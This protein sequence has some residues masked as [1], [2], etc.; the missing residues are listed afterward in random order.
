M[1][2]Q[3][4]FL[5]IGLLA[6]TVVML[7]ACGGGGSGIGAGSTVSGVAATGM[8]IA[9]GQVSL[10]CAVGSAG[11]TTTQADGNFSID[12]S[13][14]TLPCLARVDFVDS[15][16]AKKKLHSV[17]QVAGNVNITPLTDMVVA[18]LSANGIA[19]SAFDKLDASQ[20]QAFTSDRIKT[21]IQ[22]VKKELVSRGV[23]VTQLPD[24]VIGT[25]FIAATASRKGDSHDK[26]LDD[27]HSHLHE[28]GETLE[29]LETEMSA[30]HETRGF[31]TS[32][33]IPGNAEVGKALYETNC[34]SCHGPR[35]PDA[36]NSAKILEAIRENE[37][38]MKKLASVINVTA[39]DDIATYMA[40]GFTGV[41]V[42]PL[43]TQTITFASPGN[44]TIG[45][46]T[47]ALVATSS[48]GLAVLITS[49]TPAVCSVGGSTLV[50][51]ASGTC[52][53]SANQSGN[54]TYNAAVTVTNSFTVAPS[55][56]PVPTAQTISFASPGPQ[57]VGATVSLTASASSGLPVV[58]ASTTP[59]VC[60]VT[61][62]VLTSLTVG[63]C[64]VTAN[65]SGNTSFAAAPM[66]SRTLSVTS[67]A[68][69]TSA[70]NGKALY[71]SNSCGNC[72]G[73]PPA[74]ANVL[75]GAN[76]P[77][78]IQNAIANVGG[79]NRFA[80]LTSQNLA[81]IAAYLATPNI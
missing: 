3:S 63:N 77:T 31:S 53:L 43:K 36:V 28:H 55:S 78:G 67:P 76:N 72:H 14:V 44:Q 73:T 38:G 17:V 48:S 62:N 70:I 6:S 35:M 51:L 4:S 29:D 81:D 59:T 45:T 2:Y 50:L 52:S 75:N 71:A 9:N 65:Q 56:G 30:G 8:A 57:I 69:V 80:N 37:G 23:D 20:A 42:P 24:D 25:K 58:L 46:V 1:F 61:G 15:T 16:G 47:P 49:N 34:Q 39:A 13:K 21:A 10:K 33:G 19:A 5:K 64:I 74:F 68:P 40:F 54:A 41:P 66:V 26:V 12:V 79:M 18:N 22:A 11:P 7:T 32:T 27:L 60:T